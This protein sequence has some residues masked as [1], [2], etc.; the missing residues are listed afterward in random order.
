M[1]LSRAPLLLSM[2]AAGCATLFGPAVVRWA[3]PPAK[4]RTAPTLPRRD[5][6]LKPPYTLPPGRPLM[7][8]GFRVEPRSDGP[9]E[10]TFTRVA[11]APL[12][13]DAMI[14]LK[15]R[16]DAALRAI[17]GVEHVG[18][19]GCP[20]AQGKPVPC[21]SLSLQLCAEP[22]EALAEALSA[23]FETD[24]AARG[25]QVVV[26]VALLGAVA[27]R[28]EADDP[29]CR[30]DPYEGALYRQGDPRGLITAPPKDAEPECTWDGECGRSA[31]GGDCLPWTTAHQSGTCEPNPTL[32][33][34]LCGCVERRCAWFVQ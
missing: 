23:I 4:K 14:E 24:A 3:E 16:N 29:R 7:L 33:S 17:D 19:S 5:E 13:A 11:G 15:E 27:P 18:L 31:C 1:K 20:G 21:L 2:L 22:L 8:S 12:E 32:S 28:C 25:R 26:H 34:A 6:C 30:P 10:L 9:R